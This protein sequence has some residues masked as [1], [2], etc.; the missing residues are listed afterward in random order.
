M[1]KYIIVVLLLTL[2]QPAYATCSVTGFCAPS[3]SSLSEPGLGDKYAPNKLNQIQ[4]P[5]A[6]MPSY[7]QPYYDMLIN[8]EQTQPNTSPGLNNESSY[9]SNCQFGMCIPSTGVNE[10]P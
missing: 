10:E 4:K 9:N 6:F 7:R 8:T 2:I 5:T 1:S 3:S